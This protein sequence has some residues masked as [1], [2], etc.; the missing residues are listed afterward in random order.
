MPP[1]PLSFPLEFVSDVY[2][3]LSLNKYCRQ[4]SEIYNIID[5]E[6]AF[7]PRGT[8]VAFQWYLRGLQDVWKSKGNKCCKILLNF[9]LK[10]LVQKVLKSNSNLVIYVFTFIFIGFDINLHVKL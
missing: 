1:I 4:F 6:W 3:L 8:N 9:I 7:V 5:H 2:Y 10:V